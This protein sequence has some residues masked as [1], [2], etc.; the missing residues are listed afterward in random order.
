MTVKPIAF[1]GF[2]NLAGVDKPSDDIINTCVRCGL[3][4]QSCPTYT[5]LGRE[6][7]S[8]RGR[9]ALIRGVAEGRLSVDAPGF[10]HQMDECLGCLACQAVCPS[11]V[12]YGH[13]LEA[14]RAQARAVKSTPPLA[15]LIEAVVFKV[16]FVNM[17]LFRLFGRSMWLY[18]KLG[19]QALVRQWGLL[20]LLGLAGT[21]KLLPVVNDRF[22]YAEGQRFAPIRAE[23][24]PIP[25]LKRVALLTGC[26]Q[27]VAFAHVHEA[28]INTLQVNGCEV[29]LPVGQQCCGALHQ[30]GGDF[31]QARAL[32]RQNIDA[33]EAV[34]PDY[35]VVNAAGCSHHLKEYAHMLKDDPMYA[36]RAEKF[37]AKARDITELLAELGPVPATKP[38]PWRVTYQEPCHLAHGQKVVNPPRQILARIP[39]LE[40][41][42]MKDSAMCCGSAGTYNIMQPEMAGKL[43]DN[44]LTHAAETGATVIASANTGC[45]I[46]MQAGLQA[47]GDTTKLMHIVEILDAAYRHDG[48][49][50]HG[51]VQIKDAAVR[52]PTGPRK[53]ALMV[54]ALAAVV[55]ALW[56]LLSRRKKTDVTTQARLKSPL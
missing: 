55:L 34:Q 51:Q 32:A 18:Q 8:P 38:L 39:A 24:G 1:Q 17:A 23:S 10:L 45:M 47:R 14:G 2:L 52:P 31:E 6:P 36:A 20:Q 28:T 25:R 37:V 27:S 35:V 33:L 13:L 54:V 9:I 11:G 44:K 56:R 3:C 26:V 5:Q 41:I 21:E 48:R 50:H 43:L 46:Q 19:V 4:L 16:L 22:I 42:E 7:S 15:R 12:Q 29:V 53:T 30:H 49:Y 40:L